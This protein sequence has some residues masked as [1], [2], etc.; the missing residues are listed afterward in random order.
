MKSL[1][2]RAASTVQTVASN[3]SSV[4][5]NLDDSTGQQQKLK[6]ELR[7]LHS[8]LDEAQMQNVEMSKQTQL[9]IAEKE[10]EITLWIEKC[11]SIDSSN[12]NTKIDES[13]LDIAKLKAEKKVIETMMNKLEEKLR[14]SVRDINESKII[15]MKFNELNDKYENLKC[16]YDELI[17]KDKSRADTIENLVAEYSKLAADSADV[18]QSLDNQRVSDSQRLMEVMKE[19]EVL[20]TK[21]HA[22]ECNISEFADRAIMETHPNSSNDRTLDEKLKEVKNKVVNLQFDLKEKDNMIAS[23]NTQVI[24]LQKYT[25]V[26][27][28]V[29]VPPSNDDLEKKL[30]IAQ[31]EIS[32]L[33]DDIARLQTEKREAEDAG[34]ILTDDLKR[35]QKQYDDLKEDI[36]EKGIVESAIFDNIDATVTNLKQQLSESEQQI[37]SL[38]EEKQVIEASLETSNNKY[39]LFEE[40]MLIKMNKLM[41]TSTETSNS[42]NS[43][44]KLLEEELADKMAVL[45]SLEVSMENSNSKYKL[46]EEEMASKMTIIRSLEELIENEKQQIDLLRQKGDADIQQALLEKKQSEEIGTK[47]L[48]EQATNFEIRLKSTL[49]EYVQKYNQ[50]REEVLAKQQEKYEEAL[51]QAEET[52]M[53]TMVEAETQNLEKT[54]LL[55]EQ[56][57]LLISNADAAA[58]QAKA[59][60]ANV[61]ERWV[62]KIKQDLTALEKKKNMEILTAVKAKED[63]MMEKVN[64]AETARKEFLT[65][66]TKESKLRKS[67]HNKLIELQG[68]IRVVCRVRPIL[69]VEKDQGKDADITNF[70]PGDEDIIISKEGTKTRYEYDQVF[71]PKS[72]Q[73][74]VFDAQFKELC[75]SVLDGF[76]VCIFC[77]GQTGSGKTFTME[78]TKDDPGISPL[79]IS[80]LF[81][82]VAG[83]D[84]WTY[85]LT[86]SMLEI[87]NETIFDL[88]ETSNEKLEIRQGPEGNVVVGLTEVDITSFE[89]VKQL[90]ALG[91]NNRAVGAHE[92]NKHSSRSHSIL[93]VSCRGKNVIDNENSFGKLHLIDLAGSER[94]S[95]TDAQGDRLKEAQNINRSLSALGDV[96][97]ALGNRKSTHVPF[98]NSKLTFLLQDS[99]GGNSKVMMCV[100]ISPAIYNVGE[101]ICSLNFASRCRSVELGQ[102]KKNQPKDTTSKD[103]KGDIK[104]YSVP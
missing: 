96:I 91:N 40:E 104:K 47:R 25:T 6:D 70:P 57:K 97:A 67:L 56:Y 50:E 2:E 76:N 39:K 89:E 24:T 101:T 20:V 46:L 23:L 15:K 87:Y 81:N 75:V 41:E 98:R 79:A 7:L 52:F 31:N 99:L 16:D 26:S 14:D 103:S 71:P 35:I 83:M 77:Y 27:L 60:L 95:K 1:W 36:N 82:V 85:Q 18:K 29:P 12:I 65:L 5:D 37:K 11:N 9:L 8:L 73:R 55:E 80:E 30:E 93:T 64:S 13:S 45:R 21:M 94:V 38:T 43:K 28:G 22:L 102:A 33:R 58:S 49:E 84:N 10:A 88:I 100:N 48:E 53:S 69:D 3:V 44:Y 62:L 68:N 54:R 61:E 19:N 17:E 34:R 86:L 78:G 63:E 42:T 66:Y 32:G 51:A 74:E 92:M 4:L 59:D 90:M 72:T